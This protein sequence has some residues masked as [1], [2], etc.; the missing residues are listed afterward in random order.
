MK[1]GIQEPLHSFIKYAFHVARG[2]GS[3]LR[4]EGLCG[5]ILIVS[6]PCAVPVFRI[7]H[8]IDIPSQYRNHANL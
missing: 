7:K 3:N 5:I 2:L 4:L 6:A 1:G 8:T